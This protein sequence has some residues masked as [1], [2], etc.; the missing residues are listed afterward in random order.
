MRQRIFPGFGRMFAVTTVA[1][2]LLA[3]P[4][5]AE[6]AT[7]RPTVKLQKPQTEISEAYYDKA[8]R[9]FQIGSKKEK[10]EV[11][12]ALRSIV[13]KSPEEFMAHYYLGI[14][15][16]EEGSPGQALRHF[17]TALIGFP[18]SADIHARMGALLD[19]G[20]KSDAAVEHYRKALELEPN[21]ARALSRVGIFELESGNL[22]K[23]YDLLIKARQVQPDNPETL[24]ALGAIYIEKNAAG[25]ALPIL[26]QALLFDQKHAETHWLLA[27]TFE[28]LNQPEKAAEHFAEARKLGRKDPEIKELIGYDLARSLLQAGK[29]AEAEAE[30]KKEIKKNSDPG[31]G[32]Y[33]LAGLYEDSGRE[34]AAI[35]AY[36]EAYKASKKF[37]AGVM[38]AA[39]IYLRRENYDRA[40][41]TLELL[42]SD[43]ELKDKAKIAIEELKE[44]REK[45]E[46]LRL[47]AEM[48]DGKMGDIGIEANFL[49]MLDLNKSDPTALEGL[50]NFYKDRGYY[51]KALYW[52]KK[53]NKVHPTSDFQKKLIEEDLKN[54]YDLDNFSLFGRKLVTK[55]FK[56]R[57][58]LDN[59]PLSGK[60]MVDEDGKNS[61]MIMW[62]TALPLKESVAPDDNLMNLAFNGENDRLKEIAFQILL[63][64]QEYKNDR[65]V[66][67][68]L[69]DFYAERGRIDDA[70]KCVNSLKR[71]GFYTASEATEKRAKLRGK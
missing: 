11:V 28:K 56:G 54:R 36:L 19:V 45:Q 10:A 67:E 71:L 70:L 31:T 23:A 35:E 59:A 63:V 32:H 15:I 29:V 60:N 20:K 43:P 62:L 55:D 6:P 26:E 52:F 5:Q 21:N 37:G 61:T 3:V 51:E 40:E 8:W 1:A 33:E 30:F 14:M 12:K 7:R 34:D 38:K 39:D 58:K 25:E 4:Y 47:A 44:T 22:D 66:I 69:M 49:Q 57:S 18:N 46:K 50:M 16:S 9:D 17:E 27:R 41:A 13:R 53:Y 2:T 68:G 24:R 48:E 65:R 42:K 64:R